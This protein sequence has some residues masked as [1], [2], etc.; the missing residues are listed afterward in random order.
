MKKYNWKYDFKDVDGKIKFG[1][2]TSQSVDSFKKLPFQEALNG[3]DSLIQTA[4]KFNLNHV[5]K[6]Y[7]NYSMIII[8]E[9]IEK[10]YCYEVYFK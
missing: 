5:A 6:I 3:L 2:S 7:L 8:K 10:D 4:I 1:N 9:K